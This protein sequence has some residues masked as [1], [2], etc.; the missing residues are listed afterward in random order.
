MFAGLAGLNG[1][2]GNV[3]GIGSSIGGIAGMFG[4]GNQSN[5]MMQQMAQ[6]SLGQGMMQQ[7]NNWY[8]TGLSG[9]QNMQNAGQG[10]I[11]PQVSAI[12]G[13]GGQNFSNASGAYR[14]ALSNQLNVGANQIQG[15]MGLRNTQEAGLSGVYG[16]LAGGVGQGMAACLLY[17]SRRG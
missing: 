9:I 16:S 5:Q 13:A 1:I 6:N 8:N 14:D 4:G 10:M 7:G 3:A 17:T 15:A 11:N 12:Y 2:L